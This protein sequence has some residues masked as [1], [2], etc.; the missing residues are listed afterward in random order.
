MEGPLEVIPAFS[1]RDVTLDAYVSV[2]YSRGYFS[3]DNGSPEETITLETMAGTPVAGSVEQMGEELLLFVPAAPLAPTTDYVGIATG[4]DGD[5][6]FE[7][8]TGV[9]V[10]MVAPAVV[11]GNDDTKLEVRPVE[12]EPSCE[13]PDGGVRVGVTVSRAS[14][15]GPAGSVEYLLYLTRAPNLT[16]PRLVARARNFTSGTEMTL[17]FVLPAENVGTTACVSLVVSDGVG[18]T[19][20]WDEPVCFDPVVETRFLGLCTQSVSP[21]RVPGLPVLGLFVAALG[22]LTRRAGRRRP[23]GPQTHD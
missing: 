19:S 13:A 3:A 11:E 7:F 18:R 12:V 22:V 20:R 6:E 23:Q 17:A 21:R 10:D 14:D 8:R 2:R 9:Q 4:P 15:D 5:F 1:A 16:A